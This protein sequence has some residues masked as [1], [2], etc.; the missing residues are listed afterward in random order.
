MANERRRA[1]R[2]REFRLEGAGLLLVSGALIVLL[3]GAF[4]LGRWYE[5]GSRPDAPRPVGGNPLANVVPA[6]PQPP[7][8]VD[9]SLTYFDSME[10]EGKEAE[11]GRE[12]APKTAPPPVARKDPKPATGTGFYVQVFAGRDEEAA[13]GLVQSLEGGGYDARLFTEREGT[14]MLYKVRVGGYDTRESAADVAQSLKSL[15]YTGA[16]VTHVE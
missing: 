9:S 7:K 12:I 13:A 4:W 8:D 11:P 15:G 1:D 6:E 5:R 2:D 10:G 16:W 14:G 3:G